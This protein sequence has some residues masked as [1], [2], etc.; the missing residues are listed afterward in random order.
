V[1]H[2]KRHK[3]HNRLLRQLH[4]LKRNVITR[5]RSATCDAW[6]SSNGSN[7]T[8]SAELTVQQ[9]QRRLSVRRDRFDSS[10]RK[11]NVSRRRHDRNHSNDV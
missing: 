2:R 9:A 4:R 1:V 11:V 8:N 7:R 5:Q 3:R 6:S 10:S